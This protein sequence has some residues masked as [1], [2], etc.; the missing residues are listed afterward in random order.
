MNEKYPHFPPQE[1]H[2]EAENHYQ[3]LMEFIR[4]GFNFPLLQFQKEYQEKYGKPAFFLRDRIGSKTNQPAELDTAQKPEEPIEVIRRFQREAIAKQD[5]EMA[6]ANRSQEILAQKF[7]PKATTEAVAVSDA[8]TEESERGWHQDT[9]EVQQVKK[10]FAAVLDMFS[11]KRLELLSSSEKKADLLAF[12]IAD[13]LLYRL[14]NQESQEV[15]VD[16]DTTNKIELFNK[17]YEKISALEFKELLSWVTTK[18]NKYGTELSQAENKSAAELDAHYQKILEFFFNFLI[19][20]SQQG[21]L[22]RPEEWG[23]EVKIPEGIIDEQ[24]L[25]EIT[26]LAQKNALARSEKL[27]KIAD[28]LVGAA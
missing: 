10:T 25:K 20:I 27:K 24:H 8:I 11:R 28:S 7:D 9:K 5:R 6:E 14:V 18:L 4:K 22:N 17:V 21:N 1:E 15:Q 2:A 16:V 19:A 26:K 23:S 3:R 13:N 12:N